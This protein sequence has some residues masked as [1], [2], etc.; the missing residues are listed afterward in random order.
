MVHYEMLIMRTRLL[1]QFVKENTSI[2]QNIFIFMPIS[3]LSHHHVK[4][5]SWEK[6]ITLKFN[7]ELRMNIHLLISVETYR[8]NCV[9]TLPM[10]L[11]TI[12][13]GETLELPDVFYFR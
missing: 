13:V 2:G 12:D 10:Q 3:I 6:N 8:M 5:V 11:R 4:N 9:G 7:K 1:S